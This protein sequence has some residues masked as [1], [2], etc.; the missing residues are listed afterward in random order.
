MRPVAKFLSPASARSTLL[1][2]NRIVRIVTVLAM[3]IRT[4]RHGTM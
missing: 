4:S 2:P 3:S 1:R